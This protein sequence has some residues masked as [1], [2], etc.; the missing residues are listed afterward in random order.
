MVPHGM[1]QLVETL[2]CTECHQQRFKYSPMQE[3]QLDIPSRS[4]RF[5]HSSDDNVDVPASSVGEHP[6][7][8]DLLRQHFGAS[9]REYRCSR[10]NNGTVTHSSKIQRLPR[11]LVIQLKRFQY[12]MLSNS[13]KKNQERV[14][15]P[16]TFDVDD[17]CTQPVLRPPKLDLSPEAAQYLRTIKQQQFDRRSMENSTCILSG[18]SSSSEPPAPRKIPGVKRKL[19]LENSKFKRLKTYSS[20]SNLSLASAALSRS[21]AAPVAAATT[22]GL[23]GGGRT[24]PDQL[25]RAGPHSVPPEIQ[26]SVTHESHTSPPSVSGSDSSGSSDQSVPELF[27]K[28]MLYAQH[29][30]KKPYRYTLHAVVRHLSNSISCGHYTCDARGFPSCEHEPEWKN[31]WYRY[32]DNRVE[33]TCIEA[34]TSERS[35][36]KAY[37]LFYVL[38]DPENR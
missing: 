29:A 9:E 34:V 28:S 15:F 13:P 8:M 22:P 12:D 5:L 4:R 20:H 32:D 14:Q 26:L 36:Q 23:R 33:E 35:Q 27:S 24:P 25:N 6:T 10:C 18:S 30:T 11:I 3:L 16:E 19:E 37:L 38:N 2:E 1:G 17:F 21:S 7:L 31:V